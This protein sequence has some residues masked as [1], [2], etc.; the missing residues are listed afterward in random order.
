[1]KTPQLPRFL[2]P[3]SLPW[4]IEE[5]VRVDV[6]LGNAMEPFSAILECISV[7]SGKQSTKPDDTPIQFNPP[8]TRHAP[9]ENSSSIFIMQLVH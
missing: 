7:L 2:E 5:R 4:S 6:M 9:N 3:T 1:M 8:E